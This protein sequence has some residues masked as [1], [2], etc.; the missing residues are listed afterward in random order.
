[1]SARACMVHIYAAKCIYIET[2]G[3]KQFT[4]AHAPRPD[5]SSCCLPHL[6]KAPALPSTSLVIIC[7]LSCPETSKGCL[8]ITSPLAKKSKP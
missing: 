2:K 5:H 6:L 8:V 1:V 3:T 7:L 4:L